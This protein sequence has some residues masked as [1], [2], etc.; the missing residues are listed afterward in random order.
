MKKIRI[1]RKLKK[2][3]YAERKIGD[4][5]RNKRHNN[6]PKLL[7][8]FYY[9]EVEEVIKTYHIPPEE[10]VRSYSVFMIDEVIW[11]YWVRK[12]ELGIEPVLNPT[13]QECWNA[14]V[15]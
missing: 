2:R 11:W 5:F 13:Y 14:I 12:K 4:I 1:P 3:I 9:Y 10:I 15:K 8:Y 7:R 6:T